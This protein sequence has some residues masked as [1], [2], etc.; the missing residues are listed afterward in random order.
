MDLG[1]LLWTV[2]DIRV[3]LTMRSNIVQLFTIFKSKKRKKISIF[4]RTAMICELYPTYVSISVTN[5]HL[6]TMAK[7][8]YGKSVIPFQ[9]K[10]L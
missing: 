7:H 6:N 5:V 8:C 9:S 3:F 4:H 1:V 2:V 10:S